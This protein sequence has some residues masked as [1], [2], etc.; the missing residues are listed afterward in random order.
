MAVLAEDLL[1]L[2][3]DEDRPTEPAH[4][5]GHLTVGLVAALL[6]DLSLLGRARISEATVRVLDTSPTDDTL[7]DEVL[8]IL[9]STRQL[10]SPGEWLNGLPRHLTMLEERLVDRLVA[11]GSLRRT[12]DG[13]VATQ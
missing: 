4:Y 7:L 2:A 6:G 11:R 8:H 13:F 3:F 10:F 5:R 9:A 12:L 1:L